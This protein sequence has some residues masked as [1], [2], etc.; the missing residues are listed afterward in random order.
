[1]TDKPDVERWV[2]DGVQAGYER[3]SQAQE[4]GWLNLPPWEAVPD[5][6]KAQS[7]KSLQHQIA[8]FLRAAAADGFR[9]V[10]VP[11]HE[12]MPDW[13]SP[14]PDWPQWERGFNACRSAT[15]ASAVEVGE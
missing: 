9:L 12:E 2:G 1:M 6:L 13:L 8:A 14:S 15:L 4:S 11:G 10:R 5:A 3:M 7:V